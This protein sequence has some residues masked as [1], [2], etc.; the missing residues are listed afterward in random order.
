MNPPGSDRTVGVIGPGAMG[1]GIVDS[2][3]RGGFRVVARD[4]RPEADARARAAGAEIAASPADVA[5]AAPIVIVVVVDARQ[6]DEVLF[7]ADGIAGAGAGDRVVLIASTLDPDYVRDLPS[8]A[9]S[10]GVTILDTP[11]SGG[12]AKAHDGT[13]TIMVA[14]AADARAR[15][16]PVLVAIAGRRFPISERA[17][18]AAATKIVN[19]LLAGANLAAAAEA[20]ALAQALGLDVD[21]TADV[22]AAS[23]GASWIFA[24]R[25]PRALA[26]DWRPRA[27]ARILAKDV[28]IACD[29]AK[30]AH[31]ADTFAQA[32]RRAFA[33]TVEAGYGE[34]DDAAII[35][36]ARE[37]VGR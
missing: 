20:L 8:R 13:M 26:G 12:P 35:R 11:I 17:G 3:V 16:E 6:V 33:D 10:A 25:V 9:E 19:N 28:G 23:S 18:D 31:A 14:G 22:I 34:D 37:R 21:A 15:V 27:A 2:L 24:D 30:R 5:R 29:V 32:A 4:I 1:L 7:G 36:R